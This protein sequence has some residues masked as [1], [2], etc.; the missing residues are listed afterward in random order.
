MLAERRHVAEV[1]TDEADQRA[2]HILDQKAGQHLTMD[3]EFRI[4][5]MNAAAEL[6]FGV[7]RSSL[8]TGRTA[9]RSRRQQARTPRSSIGVQCACR[10]HALGKRRRVA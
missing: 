2:A 3:T 7:L 6:G 10:S 5:T 8:M 1:A 4:L 9:W